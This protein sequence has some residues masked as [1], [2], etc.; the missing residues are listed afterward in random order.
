V[1]DRH[2]GVIVLGRLSKSSIFTA[3]DMKLLMALASQASIALETVRLHLEEIQ[4]Q[5]LEEELAISCQIQ[6]SLLPERCPTTPG[7]E[8]AATYQA[9]RQVGGDLYDFIYLPE[10]PTNKIGLVIADVAGK[11]IP[12]AL[13]MAFCRTLIRMEA[14]VE[15]TPAHVLDATNQS[16]IQN[17]RSELFLSAFYALLDLDNGNLKFANGGHNPPYWFQDSTGKCQELNA[18]GY[19]LGLFNRKMP[20]ERQIVVNPGDLLVFYT[21]GITEARDNH[22]EFFGEERLESAILANKTGSAQEVLEGIVQATNAFIGDTPQSDDF[23]L[24]VI[25]RINERS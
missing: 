8:F 17:S 10:Q 1:K 5:R 20:E 12:A 7:W 4:K 25:K 18:K 2:Q 13:F 9:A 15:G 14:R 6:L 24:F 22:G 3:G 19:L 16:I 11:G 21:D 23:T